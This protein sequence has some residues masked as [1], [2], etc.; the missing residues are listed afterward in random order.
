MHPLVESR[1]AQMVA[2]CRRFGVARLELIG[3]AAR[4]DFDAARGALAFLVD[5][6]PKGQVLPFAFRSAAAIGRQSA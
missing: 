3:S 6:G 2:L 4:D 1:R 5:L